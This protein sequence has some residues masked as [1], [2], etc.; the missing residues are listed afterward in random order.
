MLF[1]CGHG[2][3][4]YVEQFK[5]PHAWLILLF[6]GYGLVFEHYRMTDE[7]GGL[8][9][10]QPIDQ[11]LQYDFNFQQTTVLPTPITVLPVRLS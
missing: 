9:Q 6:T 8:E 10:L 3:R 1:L 2:T 7:C 5:L 11:N 4:L